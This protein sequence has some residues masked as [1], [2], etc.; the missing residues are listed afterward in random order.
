[1]KN[2]DKE[3]RRNFRRHY[4]RKRWQTLKRKVFSI[5]GTKKSSANSA[6]FKRPMRNFG[7][8]AIM[9]KR[10]RNQAYRKALISVM[11]S[12][13]LRNHYIKSL[14]FSLLAAIVSFIF[15]YSVYELTT[16]SVAR[17]FSIPIGWNA[18]Q[19]TYPLAT[20]SP[21]YTK[22]ALIIIFLSGPIICLVL[23]LASRSLFL[24]SSIKHHFT[25]LL[26]LWICVHGFN[27]FFGSVIVGIITRT[28]ALYATMW[29]FMSSTYDLGEMILLLISIFML[30]IFGYWITPLFLATSKIAFSIQPGYRMITLFMEIIIPFL[31]AEAVLITI[32]F[33]SLYLPF[34]L[35]IVTSAIVVVPIVF[36]YVSIPK[37]MLFR[38]GIMQN[39]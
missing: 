17:L 5:F 33:P 6:D 29:F 10:N 4:R 15:L 25:R 2:P 12:S 7:N 30:L 28:E 19:F 8:E 36:R 26:S 34:I 11:K 18:F 37:E 22:Y 39:D 38:Y 23:S 32:S 21:L 14:Y 24:G 1:M 3:L 9:V 35:K 20:G 31:I 16:I 13:D 27:L